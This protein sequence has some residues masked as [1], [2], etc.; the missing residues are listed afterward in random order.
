MSLL[1]GGVDAVHVSTSLS[2]VSVDEQG[3]HLTFDSILNQVYTIQF[4]DCFHGLDVWSNLTDFVGV[5]GTGSNVA[6]I[7]AEVAE[8]GTISNTRGRVYRLSI[9]L[10]RG[11]LG[12]IRHSSSEYSRPSRS[13]R[14]LYEQDHIAET[15]VS[16]GRA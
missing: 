1:A 11:R 6:H 8:S 13:T 3:A 4:S 15:M 14:R 12:D 10:E 5:S 2:I 7:N 9:G 16:F